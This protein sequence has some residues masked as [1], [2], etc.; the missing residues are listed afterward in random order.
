MA[1]ILVSGWYGHKNVGDELMAEALRSLLS[2]HELKFVD[3]VR[4]TDLESSNILLIGGGSFLSLPFGMDEASCATIVKKPV[5]YVGVGAE[6]GVHH[7]HMRLLKHASAVFVRSP[8][9]EQF[10]AI[11]PAAALTPDLGL[12][13]TAP[14]LVKRPSREIL[15]LANSQVLPNRTS[16]NWQRAAWDYFKSEAAQAIDE[17]IVGGWNVTMAPFCDDVNHRDSWACAELIAHCVERRRVRCLDA[18]WYDDAAF[19]KVRPAFDASSVVVTQRYHGAIISQATG[20]PCVVIHH[21]D[22]LARIDPNVAKLIPYYGIRKDALVTAIES[23]EVPVAFT[24]SSIFN[25]VRDA[26]EKALSKT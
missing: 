11:R 26:I 24:N 15:F 22:K 7:D 12:A 21:H 8:A 19:S 16:P 6:T 25:E 9:S 17:L 1:K 20:A 2:G 14:S 13:L 3:H 18:T 10:A 23:A 5:I 4:H